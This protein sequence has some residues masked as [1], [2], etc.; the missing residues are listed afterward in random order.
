M[1]ILLFQREKK[2]C[3]QYFFRCLCLVCT[4]DE[5]IWLLDIVL[6]LSLQVKLYWKSSQE[7]RQLRFWHGHKLL[8]HPGF[9]VGKLLPCSYTE[10]FSWQKDI[11]QYFYMPA[12]EC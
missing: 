3:Q 9:C 10:I 11:I 6:R 1:L 7:I 5:T 2:T 8:T 4:S 12:L